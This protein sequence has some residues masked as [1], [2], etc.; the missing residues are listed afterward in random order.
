MRS[1]V[2]WLIPAC[3]A[4]VTLQCTSEPDPAGPAQPPPVPGMRTL[5]VRSPF[6]AEGAALLDIAAA[7]VTA[8][9]ASGSDVHTAVEGSRLRILIVRMVPGELAATIAVTDTAQALEARLLQVAGPM[10]ELRASLA[11]YVLEV[12][13]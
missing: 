1:A 10:N 12:R 8:V 3:L 5:V 7:A 2:P 13:R 11:T 4:L 9:T 6:G